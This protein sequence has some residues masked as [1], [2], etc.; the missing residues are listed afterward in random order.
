MSAIMPIP[1]SANQPDPTG[2]NRIRTRK[3]IREHPLVIT[4]FLL[5]VTLIVRASKDALPSLQLFDRS[6]LFPFRRCPFRAAN[7]AAATFNRKS[8]SLAAFLSTHS[9]INSFQT[10]KDYLPP[11]LPFQTRIDASQGIIF[12]C[13][14]ANP[15]LP[16]STATFVSKI[17]KESTQPCVS[18]CTKKRTFCRFIKVCLSLSQSNYKIFPFQHCSTLLASLFPYRS[19]PIVNFS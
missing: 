9:S 5:L 8:K 15:F 12:G 10:T 6:T 1:V 4:L 11:P 3:S 17:S 2:L 7:A 13:G 19:L 16:S 18:L 14:T